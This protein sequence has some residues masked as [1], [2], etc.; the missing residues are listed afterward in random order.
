MAKPR[1]RTAD[2]VIRAGLRAATEEHELSSAPFWERWEMDARPSNGIHCLIPVR[3]SPAGGIHAC[4]EY[5]CT[6]RTIDQK[7]SAWGNPLDAGEASG[8]LAVPAIRDGMRPARR[9]P[10]ALPGR[11]CVKTL[12]PGR[13][14]LAPDQLMC[15]RVDPTT[16][17]P[18]WV[19]TNVTAQRSAG[20]PNHVNG[21]I[22]ACDSC[23]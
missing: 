21:S 23:L 5:V 1:S 2:V 22:A 11:R 18:E 14:F 16:P 20:L 7:T 19:C 8:T 4:T 3:W 12:R 10:P 15:I 17:R 9:E 6:F 13:R